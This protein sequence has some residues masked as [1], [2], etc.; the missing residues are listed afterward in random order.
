MRLPTTLATAA[1]TVP[2]LLALSACTKESE[3]AADTTSAAPSSTGAPTPSATPSYPTFAAQDY[4]YHLEVLCFCPQ[5]G[6]V[7]VVVRDG[8][9]TEATSLDGPQAGASAPEFARLSIN[10]ILAQAH[11]PE[12]AK[13][14]IDWPDGQDHPGS[15]MIDR[16]AQ[17]VDDEVT[18]TIKDVQVTPEG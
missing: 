8:K 9:V 7:E 2:L 17:G 4:S 1:L 13:T 3:R 11:A 10:D 18:Y 14:K 15:V 16:I 6:T 12:I 5:L